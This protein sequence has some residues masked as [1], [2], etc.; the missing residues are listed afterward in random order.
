MKEMSLAFRSGLLKH[1]Q[2]NFPC[3]EKIIT[4]LL[5]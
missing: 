5:R 1:I 2:K 4:V 3:L